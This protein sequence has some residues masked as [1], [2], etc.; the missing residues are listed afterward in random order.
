MLHDMRFTLDKI[1]SRLALIQPM[2]YRDQISLPEME[3]T[4][5]PADESPAPLAEDPSL[6]WQQIAYE[7]YWGTWN[8]NYAF[9]GRYQIPE[10]WALSGHIGLLMPLGDA[11]DYF[12]HAEALMYIDSEPL[13]AVDL[14]H[15][16]VMLPPNLRN[17]KPHSFVLHGWS[18]IG[19]SLWADHQPR[20]FLKQCRLV[21]VDMP[22]REF[23]ALAR[24]A[25]D[26]ARA[27]NAAHPARA[28]LLNSLNEAFKMLDTRSHIIPEDFYASLPAATSILRQ[29]IAEAGDP[30]DVTLHAAGHAH[31]DTAWLWRFAQTRRKVE[32]T[33][34]TALHLMEQFPQYHFT[35]SQ[36]QLYELLRESHPDAFKRVQARVREK[37]WEVIGGMWIEA[38]C[39]ISGAESLARQFLLGRRYFRQ[40]FGSDAE[41]PVLW[42]PDAFGFNWNLPQ[43]IKEAGLQYFFTIKLTWNETN[44]FPYDSF[45]WQGLDG[46]RILTHLSTVP[47]VDE[48]RFP[49]T[50]NATPS[51]HAALHA[52]S[53]LRHKESQN[54]ML[55]AYGHGDGGGGPS[56]EMLEN[57]TAMQG[58]PGVPKVKTGTVRHFFE[59]L[60]E[61]S[62]DALPTWSDELYLETHRGVQTSQARTKLGNRRSEFLLHDAEF[63]ASLA[64]TLDAGFGYPADTL[65]QAW[66]LV[67]LNQFHDILP[68]SSIHEVYEDTA[69]QYAAVADM[70]ARVQQDALRVIAEATGG[71]LLLINPT[72][73]ARRDLAFWAGRLEKGQ[74]LQTAAGEPVLTQVLGQGTLIVTEELPAYSVVPLQLVPETTDALPQ[75]GFLSIEADMIENA[76]LYVQID[77]EGN[78]VRIFDK[79]ANRE[80]LPSGAIAG[81]LQAFEDR[82]LKYDAWNIDPHYDDQV[83]LASPASSIS[84]VAQG[85]LR[86]SLEIRRTIL[87]SEVIQT[88]SLDHNSPMLHFGMEVDW[89]EKHTLLKVA[90]PVDI[91]AQQASYEIQWGQIDRPTHRNT[92]WDQARYE[93]PAQKWADL[94]EGDYGVSLLNDCKYAYDVA[95]N[96]LRLSLLRAPTY[97]DAQ[98]DEGRHQFSY[99]LLPHSGPLGE[100]TRAAAYALNDRIIVSDGAKQAAANLSPQQSLVVADRPNVIIET[101]KKAEDEDAL[102][103]RLYESGRQRGPVQLVCNFPIARVW[104]VNLIED[105]Q[106]DVQH[107]EQNRIRLDLRPF[108][109]VSLMIVLER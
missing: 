21:R 92:S 109:I 12:M 93:V 76:F 72:S 95:G 100:L 22:T 19:G 107:D 90:F 32:R 80:V 31:I 46:T 34:F 85:P 33:F 50:Y 52:W 3:Y 71:D 23:I 47:E 84:I 63:L 101:I 15:P 61:A 94:S 5:L 65:T 99:A 26:A 88:I 39:N 91:L 30:L 16:L 2:I 45:W 10:S 11:G 89:R 73:F 8:T 56:I 87:S 67:C 64:M 18:G 98:A 20:L 78:I 28:R 75:P 62:G 59:M 54:H 7:Q 77:H 35:Q 58:L 79:R 37:R 105:I 60:D 49:S 36:P 27:L 102:I 82:P 41:T 81:Q 48:A 42:L 25:L 86:A 14:R 57:I 24:C 97:P 53:L 66:Q 55:M 17:H 4:A 40:H 9:R 106:Y 43:L 29:G 70:V 13:A 69:A 6:N 51:P 1:Q 38:D 104:R 83:F 103:V 96:V 108:E 44:T 68:G 74:M